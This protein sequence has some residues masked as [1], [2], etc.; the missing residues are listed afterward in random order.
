MF[1]KKKKNWFQHKPHY[2]RGPNDPPEGERKPEKRSLPGN[3]PQQKFIQPVKA[4]PVNT[5]EPPLTDLPKIESILP[6]N[7]PAVPGSP[8]SGDPMRR[9]SDADP[10]LLY[11]DP[12]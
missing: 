2:K 10:E 6:Q 9:L 8:G 11:R 12:P 1:N 3:P 4:N 5:P 7:N